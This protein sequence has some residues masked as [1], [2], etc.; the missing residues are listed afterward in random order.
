MNVLEKL[1]LYPSFH[2][3]DKSGQQMIQIIL[4]NLFNIKNATINEL[5]ELCYTSPTSVMRLCTKLG[6]KNFSGFRAAVSEYMHMYPIANQPLHA[7]VSPE[8][9]RLRQELIHV[10][11]LHRKIFEEMD[12]HIIEQAARL[13]YS[14]KECHFFSAYPN[15]LA[16]L[17][18]QENLIMDKK[19]TNYY[20]GGQTE[21]GIQSLNADCVA[22]IEAPGLPHEI[23]MRQEFERIKKTGAA[24]ILFLYKDLGC[25][26]NADL[27]IC[28]N[29][30]GS[31]L[32]AHIADYFFILLSSFYRNK[33]MS[34]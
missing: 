6:Y 23:P 14:K 32:D 15:P 30:T 28:V 19:K 5:S 11:D 26:K 22:F 16:V 29:S 7:D 2:P 17:S 8:T 13:I 18:L 21:Q 1:L 4:D 3:E 34:C 27:K 10:I 20:S 33:F 25:W 12:D 24:T 31:R 9:G